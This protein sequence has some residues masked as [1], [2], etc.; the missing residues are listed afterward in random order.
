MVSTSSSVVASEES[1]PQPSTSKASMG[2]NILPED[3]PRTPPAAPSPH[4]EG[5]KYY[6]IAP[7]QRRHNNRFNTEEIIYNMTFN[8]EAENQLDPIQTLLLWLQHLLKTLTRDLHSDDLIQLTISSCSGLDYPIALPMMK[9]MLLTLELLLAEF[10]HILNSNESFQIDKHLEVRIV[11]VRLPRGGG[12]RRPVL[13]DKWIRQSQSIIEVRNQDNLFLARATGISVAKLIKEVYVKDTEHIPDWITPLFRRRLWG[14]YRY[15]S[16][17]THE[18]FQHQFAKELHHEAAVPES[19]CGLPEAAI[20][21]TYLSKCGISLN[22]FSKPHH[23]FIFF[24]GPRHHPHV[25]DHHLCEYK[26]KR[27]YKTY[28]DGQT[29]CNGSLELCEE[30]GRYFAGEECMRL[31]HERNVCA[32]YKKCHG[33]EKFLN[34][35]SEI[36]RHKCGFLQCHTCK[37][38]YQQQSPHSCYMVPLQEDKKIYI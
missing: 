33:C 27:C 24:S 36:A 31:H 1:E 32:N 5:G 11:S 37:Q 22:I 18:H 7:V 35:A 14:R 25:K 23:G 4:D 10:R 19:E 12:R 13:L 28:E 38:S 20:F 3:D 30:C 2:D 6:V 15:T 26:C 34:G 9:I 16:I 17:S 29:Q 8:Q 21:Q